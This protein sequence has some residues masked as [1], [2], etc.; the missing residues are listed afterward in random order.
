M[1]I[2]V[3][4]DAIK[5]AVRDKIYIDVSAIEVSD[6]KYEVKCENMGSLP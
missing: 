3:A 4:S 5:M 6:F 2:N 1:E